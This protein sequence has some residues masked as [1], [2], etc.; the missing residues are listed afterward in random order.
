[1]KQRIHKLICTIALA[2]IFLTFAPKAFCGVNINI[3]AVNSSDKAKKT[4]I[5]YF[6]PRELQVKDV[7]NAGGL[8]LDYDIDKSAY[9]LHGSVDLEAKESK[10]IKV[11]V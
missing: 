5:K 3:V 4:P 11:E 7:I 1:M 2:A 6:L 8:E 10:T 9:F